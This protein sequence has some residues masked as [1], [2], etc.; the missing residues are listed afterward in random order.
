MDTAV[1]ELDGILARSGKYV[2]GKDITIADLLFYFELTNYKL[3]NLEWSQY[4]NVDEWFKLVY[5]IPEVK[6]ITHT[7]FPASQ[8]T[9]ELLS[10]IKPQASS[11]L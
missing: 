10:S 5:A 3:Y 6:Q 4:K 9:K 1:K 2:A 11:K 7:W 8:K